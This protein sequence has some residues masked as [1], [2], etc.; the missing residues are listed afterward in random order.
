[1]PQIIDLTGSSPA[2]PTRQTRS[3]T[4]QVLPPTVPLPN[5]HQPQEPPSGKPKIDHILPG[6]S[7]HSLPLPT[8]DHHALRSKRTWLF[9]HTV[10]LP[11][12]VLRSITLNPSTYRNPVDATYVFAKAEAGTAVC[13]SPDGVL[14][15]CAHCIAETLSE[16]T[17]TSSHVLVH[18]SGN[19]VSATLLAWDQARDLALLLISQAEI[20]NRPFPY[21]RIA[22]SPPKFN[23]KLLCIGHPG[24]EDLEANRSGVKTEYDALV[25]SEGTFRGLAKN[26]DPQ[27]NGDIGALKHNC[28]T[29]WGHSG[30][31]LFDRK[32]GAL[33][34]VHSSWDEETGMRRGVPLEAVMAFLQEFEMS[35]QKSF[36]EQWQWYVK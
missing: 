15:T 11:R 29:Y 31:G 9:S 25:L 14:L 32:T 10:P 18:S 36:G 19:I 3:S 1:M 35:R 34:G 7:I 22:H 33:A 6:F 24:S 12:D 4:R 17:T 27:N 26:Q 13:I 8:E 30:A 28:W 16:L 23:S 2:A 5:N 21:A 20:L